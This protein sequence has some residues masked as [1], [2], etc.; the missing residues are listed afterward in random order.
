MP[1]PLACDS[2]Q[3]HDGFGKQS[4]IFKPVPTSVLE[5]LE[6]HLAHLEGK[7]SND[8]N[9]TS[10]TLS[11]PSTPVT[12]DLLQLQDSNH[13]NLSIEQQRII[14][15]ERQRLEAFVSQARAKCTNI[16]PEHSS[17]SNVERSNSDGDLLQLFLP[18]ETTRTSQPSSNLFDDFFFQP[19]MPASSSHMALATATNA[20]SVANQ[21]RPLSQ[22]LT[23]SP[24][25]P[26]NP[27]LTSNSSAWPATGNA[28]SSANT[29]PALAKPP[30]TT[31][32]TTTGNDLDSRLAEIAG[33]LSISSTGATAGGSAV[34]NPAVAKPPPV[35]MAAVLSSNPWLGP[36]GKSVYRPQMQP[37][38]SQQQQMIYYPQNQYALSQYPSVQPPT[39]QITA[40]NMHQPMSAFPSIQSSTSAYSVQPQ[41]RFQQNQQQVS[42]TGNTLPAY[43]P[44]NPFL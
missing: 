38:Y 12:A 22:F 44:L 5:A 34:A 8:I 25:N 10:P 2:L 7:K 41:F 31:N 21:P 36:G 6:G 40:F 35:V 39:N 1:T 17:T 27:F 23:E 37:S 28:T 11:P 24:P 13:Q 15:E 29:L 33:Q 42:N 18:P 20:S 3:L 14:E 9:K 30:T 26:N 43:N 19:T 16:T 4:L 32:I